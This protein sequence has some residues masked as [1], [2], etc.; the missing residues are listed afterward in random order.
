MP[1]ILNTTIFI[2]ACGA[3]VPHG[4]NGMDT[5]DKNYP[6]WRRAMMDMERTTGRVVGRIPTPVLGESLDHVQEHNKE[7]KEEPDEE[8]S[9]EPTEE[10]ADRQPDEGSDK[11]TCRLGYHHT[12]L[13]V[14][15]TDG[16]LQVRETEIIGRV[17]Q[18]IDYACRI[19]KLRPLPTQILVILYGLGNPSLG[20]YMDYS[21]GYLEPGAMLTPSMILAALPT[22]GEVTLVMRTLVPEAWKHRYVEYEIFLKLYAEP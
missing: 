13:S 1:I 6:Y 5:S 12:W 22:D 20:C 7:P 19:A 8:L 11:I 16:F 21:K 17:L 15:P 14:M 2:G 3:V 4:E 10:T 9:E 18:S